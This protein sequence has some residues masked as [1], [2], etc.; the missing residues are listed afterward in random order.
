[1]RSARTNAGAASFADVQDLAKRTENAGTSGA[2]AADAAIANAYDARAREYV[3]LAGAVDQMDPRDRDAIA[4][5]RDA[6]PG[7]LLDAGC[8]P[9]HWTGFLLDGDGAGDGR[10]VSGID[11]SAEFIASARSR[12]PGIRFDRASFRALPQATASIGGILAWYSL[13]HTPPADT[14]DV[15]AEFARVVA[16]GGSILIGYFE[17]EAR[18]PFAHAVAEAHYWSANTLTDLLADA[19]FTVVSHDRRERV[20]G[21]ISSRPHGALVAVRGG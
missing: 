13:I 2:D 7:R 14:P 19:G 1:V 9:G 6:T 3:G 4:R 18:T 11:L 20:V 12:F 21:E 10:E 5:W 8:G 17:G 15:L 16:P